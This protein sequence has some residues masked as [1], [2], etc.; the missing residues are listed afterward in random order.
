MRRTT[1]NRPTDTSDLSE[2]NLPERDLS[3]ED[4]H[5][6]ERSGESLSRENRP[7]KG[8]TEG[9]VAEMTNEILRIYDAGYKKSA[10]RQGLTVTDEQV[11]IARKVHR[12][13]A[14]DEKIRPGEQYRRTVLMVKVEWKGEGTTSVI[15]QKTHHQNGVERSCLNHYTAPTTSVGENGQLAWAF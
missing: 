6:E 7:E 9:K 13:D 12:C 1:R 2:R 14:C 8:L 10:A 11:H 5:G 4:L 3:G 15:V